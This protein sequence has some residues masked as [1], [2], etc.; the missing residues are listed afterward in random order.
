MKKLMIALAAV[1]CAAGVQAASI[2][3]SSGMNA[4]TAKGGA[5]L[6]SGKT[7][8]FVLDSYVA[9]ITEAINK[10]T[11]SSSTEGVL[12]AKAT[13]NTKGRFNPPPAATVTSSL[14]KLDAEGKGVSTDFRLLVVD[15][16]SVTGE[17]WYKFSAIT[18]QATYDE[19]AEVPVPSS[20]SFTS[21]AWNGGT[22]WAKA[23]SVPEPTSAML[24]LLGVAGLALRRRR[25]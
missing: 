5:E 7:I 23:E 6:A 3:W 17:T 15:D 22:T 12:D 21:T 14:L 9:S 19:K 10:G 18:S 2:Q 20:V 4:A 8:Y 16:W 1:V 25:A 13:T 11:F 24:L